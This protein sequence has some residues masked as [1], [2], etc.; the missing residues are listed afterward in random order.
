MLRTFGAAKSVTFFTNCCTYL[1]KEQKAIAQEC[2][3]STFEWYKWF[4]CIAILICSGSVKRTWPCSWDYKPVCRGG[5]GGGSWGAHVSPSMSYAT[6]LVSNI[7]AFLD[8]I[9]G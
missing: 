4:I 6:C 8:S 9:T 2:L 1:Y 7:N 3:H 5:G